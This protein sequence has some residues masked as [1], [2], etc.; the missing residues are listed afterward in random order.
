[1]ASGETAART[2]TDMMHRGQD[3][4][5]EVH[6]GEQ[7]AVAVLERGRFA[8]EPM[9]GALTDLGYEV[10]STNIPSGTVWVQATRDDLSVLS[11]S[12]TRRPSRKSRSQLP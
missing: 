1:M 3:R 9:L 10:V 12:A 11:S 6:P 7:T 5:S 2:F 8:A 4:R